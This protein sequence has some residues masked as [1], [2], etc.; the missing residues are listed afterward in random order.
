MILSGPC[1][2]PGQKLMEHLIFCG[3]QDGRGVWGRTD[4]CTCMAESL[5][6]SP[7]TITLLSGYIPIQN[8]NKKRTFGCRH[9]HVKTQVEGGIRSA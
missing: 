2:F 4:P 5:C 7:E 1:A 9:V 8:N 3:S 6:C